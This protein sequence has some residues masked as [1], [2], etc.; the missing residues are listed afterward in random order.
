MSK[1]SV[2]WTA[3]VGVVLGLVAT[4]CASS[5]ADRHPATHSPR[6]PASAHCPTTPAMSGPTQQ[7][8]P[9]SFRT[10]WVLR[11]HDDTRPIPGNGVW[12]FRIEEH[13]DTDAAALVAALRKP[14]EVTPPGTICPANATSIGYV[15]LVDAAGDVLFPRAPLALC[16]EPQGAVIAALKGLAFHEVHATRMHQEQSQ[17][18]IDTG[19]GQM[20]TDAFT[21]DVLVGSKPA[22]ARRLFGKVPDALR[23]CLWQVK[24][25]GYPQL[26]SANTVTGAGLGTLLAALDGLPA[27]QSCTATHSRFVVIEYIRKHWF[28]G[29][30]YAEVDGCRRIQRPDHTLGRIDDATVRLLTTLSH[31]H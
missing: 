17:P 3:V 2:A 30:V 9:V 6:T 19:C 24:P 23:I 25:V 5:A 11:C 12:W 18:S 14:D 16:G 8:V 31:R 22:A 28:D 4:A 1:R 27:A 20:W 26:V 7:R 21:H 15:A 10:V 13:A 29:P